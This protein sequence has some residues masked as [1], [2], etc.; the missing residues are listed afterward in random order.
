LERPHP[1]HLQDNVLFLEAAEDLNLFDRRL[2]LH[3]V[4]HI[5][6]HFFEGVNFELWGKGVLIDH[7]FVKHYFD[8]RVEHLRS[9]ED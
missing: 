6:Q 7:A 8:L 5:V 9:L 1:V 4:C 2:A 3:Y